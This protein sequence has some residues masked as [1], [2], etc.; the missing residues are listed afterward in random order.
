MS[1]A[2]LDEMAADLEKTARVMV[3]AV[4]RER[5]GAMAD[6]PVQVV[7]G[8][9]GSGRV[10]VDQSRGADEL[11]EGHRGRGGFRSAMLGSVGMRCVLHDS[12]P[13]S[14]VRSEEMTVDVDAAQGTA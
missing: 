5:G 2:L 10:L 6:V 9:G 7:A 11:V 13:M 3:D 14:V 1:P 12:V 4:V 8:R